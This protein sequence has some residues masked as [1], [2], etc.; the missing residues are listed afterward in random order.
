[1]SDLREMPSSLNDAC[2]KLD[3]AYAEIERLS[4][5]VEMAR[6]CLSNIDL[7]WLDIFDRG[8]D[9][10]Y[11]GI[12]MGD[13]HKEFWRDAIAFLEASGGRP[14]PPPRMTEAELIDALD[15]AYPTLPSTEG[16]S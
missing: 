7:S 4:A 3:V 14:A 9:G 15:A 11:G 12:S 5:Q 13:E 1:M 16:Q 8:P 6:A 2:R 10:D